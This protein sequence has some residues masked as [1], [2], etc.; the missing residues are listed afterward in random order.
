V[1]Y[2]KNGLFSTASSAVVVAPPLNATA[3]AGQIFGGL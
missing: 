2:A 1:D 3:P